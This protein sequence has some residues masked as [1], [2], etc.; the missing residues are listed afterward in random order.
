MHIRALIPPGIDEITVN[1]LH[2]WDY[3]RTLE[4][5]CAE[6]GT[7]IM[8]VHFACMGMI[9]AE[10]RP[11]NFTNGVGTVTI[12]DKCLEQSTPI[13]A[14]IYGL[15]TDKGRTIKT[16]RLPIIE[17]TKP[18]RAH[19]V[20]AELIDRYN[21][22]AVAAEEAV[23]AL[24]AG[25]VK[26]ARAT[27]ADKAN[28]ADTANHAENASHANTAN[29]AE[30]ANYS[31]T[32]GAMVMKLVTSCEIV[33]GVGNIE[34]DVIKNNTPYLLVF[35]PSN[36]SPDNYSSYISSGVLITHRT[37]NDGM[38]INYCGGALDTMRGIWFNY[39]GDGTVKVTIT[40][41]AITTTVYAETG[42]N[43][44]LYIYA[45]GNIPQ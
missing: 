10:T 4:I 9:V 16:I 44:T 3:G 35:E 21:E 6:F 11:C 18:I 5:E 13:T 22:L 45:F 25:D 30:N 15:D 14:W 24:M 33:N 37:D 28:Q 20:P 2:Q 7:E 8:E 42:S 36:L 27:H 17:R 1:G 32:T 39:N 12:P 43:G 38:T 23:E 29:T 31:N 41:S 26:V 40:V 19:D 34:R